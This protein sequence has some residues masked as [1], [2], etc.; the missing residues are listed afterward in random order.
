[1]KKIIL[2]FVFTFSLISPQ[3][4]EGPLRRGDIVFFL[5]FP[6]TVLAGFTG[7]YLAHYAIEGSGPSGS[8]PAP[9]LGGAFGFAAA[10]SLGIAVFDYYQTKEE[11]RTELKFQSR[12]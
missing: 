7:A 11:S 2:L 5:S 1:M 10:S 3:Q 4:T 6:F 9:Y 8:L 12:F